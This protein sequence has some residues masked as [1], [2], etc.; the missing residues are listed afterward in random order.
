MAESLPSQGL[1]SPSQSPP[2]A[3]VDRLHQLWTRLGAQAWGP[4]RKEG[5]RRHEKRG[6]LWTRGQSG[7]LA[8]W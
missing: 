3:L 5:G 8:M 6:S 2:P 1:G 7:D 4:G